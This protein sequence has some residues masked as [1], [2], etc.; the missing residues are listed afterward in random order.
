MTTTSSSVNE[1]AHENQV[2]QLEPEAK[3]EQKV[4]PYSTQEEAH[5]VHRMSSKT[6]LY[7]SSQGLYPTI[8]GAVQVLRDALIFVH[9]NPT[10]AQNVP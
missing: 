7:P 8:A 4:H 9:W 2:Q 6:D 10:L 3:S 5:R 1:S